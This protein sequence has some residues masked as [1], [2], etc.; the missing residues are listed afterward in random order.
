[1]TMLH[2]AAVLVVAV[3]TAPA[4]VAQ[5]TQPTANYRAVVAKLQPF[6]EHEMRS[7]E[8]P[9]VS[10]ALVDDQKIVWSQGFGFADPEDS[11]RATAK[12]IYRVGSVSKLFTDIAV[13][14][15]VEQGKLDLDA[16]VSRYVPTFHPD[17][18]FGGEIT[19]RELM[20]H[21]SG[22]VR[23]PPVGHYFDDG[24]PTLSQTIASLNDTKL[25]YAPNTKTKYSN[26]AIALVGDVLA[27]TQKQRFESYLKHAVLEPAGMSSS[28]FARNEVP[29]RQIASAYMWTLDGRTFPAPTFDLGMAPAGSMYTTVDDLGRF[30][31]MLFA[32]GRG[33]NGQVL[34]R[35][36]LEAMW[37]P[38]FARPG[39]K[40][41]YGIGFGLS[42]LRGHRVVGHGGAIYGFATQLSALPDD[43]LGV[44]V[45]TTMDGANTVTSRI[46]DAALDMMLASRE[47]RALPTPD[48]TNALPT[49]LAHRLAGRYGTGAN[50]VDLVA[51]GDNLYVDPVRG[52]MRA[53]LR[54]LRD[55][56]IVDGRLGYG[57]RVIA[58]DDAII[59]GKDTLKRVQ[60]GKPAPAP[61]EWRGLIG[62]YGWD[63]NTLY[64][65][66]RDGKLEALIEWFFRYPLE[67]VSRGVYKFPNW[68]LYDGE[69]VVFDLDA[70][71]RAKAVTA[72]GVTFPRRKTGPEDGSQFRITPVRP[73]AELRKEALAAKPPKEKGD[74]RESDLVELVKLDSTIHLDIRYAT[75]NNFMGTPMYEEGRAFMQRPAAQAVARANAWLKERGYGLLIHDAYRPWFVTKMFWD[76]TPVDKHIF[77]ANPA[78]GS[79]HNR[80]CAVDLTLYDLST[81]EPI[82]MVGGYDEMTGRSYPDYP[83]GTSLQRWHRALLRQAME[84]QGFTVYEAEWWHFDYKDWR[85]YGIGN[86]TFEELESGER[87]VGGPS[88]YGRSSGTNGSTGAAAAAAAAGATGTSAASAANGASGEIVRPGRTG[89]A[90]KGF[91]AYAEKALRDWRAP[92]AAIAVVKNDSVVFARGYG[93][94]ELGKPDPVDANTIFGIAS[95]TKAFTS[96]ALGI[97]VD[98]KKM[99]WDDPVTKYLPWFQIEGPY[100]T[101]ELT[102]RDL[103]THRTGLPRGDRLWYASGFTRNEVLHR[104]RRLEPNWSFRSHYGYQNIMF[105]AAGEVAAAASGMSWDDLVRKKIFTPLGM[106]RTTTTIRALPAMQDVAM[107]HELRNDTVYVIPWR[108]MDNLGPAGSMNSSA[109][110]LAQWLRMQLRDGIYAGKRIMSDSVVEEMHTPQTVIRISDE[111]RKLY[112]DTHFMAYG[113][114]WS[115]RDYH[116][117]LLV[118]HGG[119]IDGMRTEIGLVPE[120]SLAIVVLA[121]L[122]GTNLPTALLYRALD[123]YMGAPARDWSKLLLDARRKS[124]AERDSSRRAFE[125]ARVA[126]TRPSLP[127]E[128]YVGVY[129]DSMY[130]DIE[131]KLDG[132]SLVAT[133]GPSYTGDLSHW[134]F[135]TFKVTWRDPSLGS[136]YFT[137]VLGPDGKVKELEMRNMG[138]F[139]RIPSERPATA[140]SY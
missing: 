7:K 45:V 31:S 22:L 29:E 95:T 140:G 24:S 68:G 46:A 130:E 120:D 74:F 10:I 98:E 108:N 11:V 117:R 86:Q 121:N 15:L 1:M 26:A 78:E 34:K 38:Q 138:D 127:L 93:V 125:A 84:M 122:D 58:L 53:P 107:P 64:I 85:H 76:A 49:G 16:P 65:L 19:L 119:V 132:K 21:R 8:L 118:S 28:A 124:E 12:T 111:S 14:Q 66:E 137:F 3:S 72:S 110:D 83:G 79:R 42:E 52:G 80:G 70:N 20:S 92:G 97:L 61:D 99:A 73:V 13:M 48:T 139:K 100:I 134:H 104:V 136:A 67:E 90:P 35:S 94:R 63:Y 17:N 4:A 27:T 33:A 5:S 129:S 43:K 40:M 6:I 115:L 77:V 54:M 96:G 71:G 9:A 135:D 88:E 109:N 41:G 69:Q 75:T 18:P 103:L 89:T 30:M 37:K 39:Q 36:T 112:D 2:C 82:T 114:G 91:D 60:L 25:V 81:G 57:E 101:R 106:T 131:V 55:T 59:V 23:E 126:N 87:A 123:A 51:L 133:M 102:V 116:G 56:L 47:K 62:E 113:L 50:A 32:G 128:S 44:V 105:M